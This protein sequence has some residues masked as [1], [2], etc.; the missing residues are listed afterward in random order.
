[1]ISGSADLGCLER[2]AHVWFLEGLVSQ[3][4]TLVSFPFAVRS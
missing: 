1:V 2:A 3:T 4:F